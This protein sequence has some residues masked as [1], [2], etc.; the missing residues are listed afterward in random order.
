[1]PHTILIVEDHADSRDLLAK[2]LEHSGY[3]VILNSQD[4]VPMFLP[5]I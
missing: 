4:I 2:L 3:A 5:R 1:M